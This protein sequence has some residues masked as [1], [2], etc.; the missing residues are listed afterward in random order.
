M[1]KTESTA[2][3]ELI[4]LVQSGQS[5][6]AASD[7]LVFQ[8]PRRPNV[9]RVST[10]VPPCAGEVPPLPR[11]RAPQGTERHSIDKLGQAQPPARVSVPPPPIRAVT[12]PSIPPVRTAPR[13][14]V[15]DVALEPPDSLI[16]T[17]P[18]LGAALRPSAPPAHPF[19]SPSDAKAAGSSPFGSTMLGHSPPSLPASGSAAAARSS[20]PAAPL[21]TALAAIAPAH[22]PADMTSHQHW[23]AD[24]AADSMEQHIHT[25]QVGRRTDWKALL[26]RLIVPMVL[27]VIAGIFVGGYF[28]FD[29]DKPR[30]RAVASSD[31]AEPVERA[32]LEPAAGEPAAVDSAGS[33]VEP[34]EE[35]AAV[36]P[37]PVTPALVAEPAPVAP[38]PA[39]ETT[40]AV[41]A[42]A[43]AM[44]RPELVDIRIDSTP[45][46]ATVM[47]VDRGKTSFVGT[48]PLVTALDPSREYDLVFAHEKG[49][50][51]VEH[52]VP[53]KTKRIAV[54]L[55]KSR[56]SR[57]ERAP[58]TTETRGRTT[59][60][61]RRITAEAAPAPTPAPAPVGEGL[62]MISSKPPCD[63]YVDGV[64]TGL[65]TP[66][67]ALRLPVGK[68]KITLVNAAEQIKKTLAIEVT[69]DQPTKVIQDFMK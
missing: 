32:A 7:D 3:N 24:D 41:V 36:E 1:A 45:P 9:P 29:G 37:A 53:A 28:A 57:T 18:N 33:V 8:A 58:R 64:A 39:A 67:R 46:G 6:P 12:L 35:P 17:T 43:P 49:P 30:A 21:T 50:S 55:P 15:A 63:I 44:V 23:F 66:Q 48:T 47:L 2:V 60:S 19:G 40:P 59:V 61:S 69:A 11:T 62:V 14:V 16:A 51:H 22:L 20:E 68:H 52:V 27:M 38:A 26:P 54:V 5:P 4:E 31:A 10:T 25:A 65:T 34:A 13:P 56:A 42:A